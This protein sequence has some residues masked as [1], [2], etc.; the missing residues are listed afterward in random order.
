[1]NTTICKLAFRESGIFAVPIALVIFA[2]VLFKPDP[3]RY[4]D[5]VIAVLAVLLGAAAA[6]RTFADY[7]SV[8]AFLFSRPFSPKRLFYIRYLF[9][10]GII[11][12][13]GMVTAAVI[14][15]GVRQSVQQI[16]FANGW[17]PMMRFEEL[18][19]LT[20]YFLSSFLAYHTTLYFMLTNRFRPP[21]HRRGIRLSL[22]WLGNLFLVLIAFGVVGGVGFTALIIFWNESTFPAC[23]I[24]EWF[25]FII[26]GIPAVI[27][28]LLLPRLG[29]H[30]YN[31]QEVES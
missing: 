11:A 4:F 5:T 14:A 19:C 16:L 17:F 18:H 1:M 27:Q 29:V 20:S 31:N 2:Y 26:F 9:G 23:R 8:R 7:G 22:R 12:V 21:L 13:T 24:G 6:W 15:G 3:L 28:F 25:L 30:C 10:L